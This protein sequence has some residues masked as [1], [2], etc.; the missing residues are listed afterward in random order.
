MI[1]LISKFSSD[2]RGAMSLI[3]CFMALFLTGAI[4][5]V[6]GVADSM[7]YRERVQDGADAVAFAGAVYHARGMNIIVTLNIL[8]AALLGLV[9]L[10]RLLRFL[11][12]TANVISCG[13]TAVPFIGAVCGSIC[14]VT[15]SARGPLRT[16][17][18]NLTNLYNRLGP[19]LSK[20]QR[21]VALAMPWI[22]E[23]KAVG[24]SLRYGPDVRFGAIASFSMVKLPR[25]ER[26]G[27]PVQEGDDSVL[28]GK[29]SSGIVDLVFKP[30][31]GIP[32]S[33]LV[34]GWLEGPLEGFVASFCG[35]GDLIDPEKAEEIKREEEEDQIDEICDWQRNI[36]RALAQPYLPGAMMSIQTA[37][38]DHAAGDVGKDLTRLQCYS[39]QRNQLLAGLPAFGAYQGQSIPDDVREVPDVGDLMD[40][41]TGDAPTQTSL[42][43]P[44]DRNRCENE[45][46]SDI[47]ARRAQAEQE[48]GGE[49]AEIDPEARRET[50]PKI[51]YAPAH[52]G[53]PYFQ[54]W[55]IVYANDARASKPAKG[56]EI[57]ADGR[58]R[59]DAVDFW[60]RLGWAQAEFYFDHEGAW[61]E[62][63]SENQA[64]WN[65]RWRA[66]LRRVTPPTV[67]ILEDAMGSLIGKIESRLS[68]V[69]GLDGNG[70][71]GDDEDSPS[72]ILDLL[73]RFG[74][75]GARQPIEERLN[76]LATDADNSI[77]GEGRRAWR[78]VGGVH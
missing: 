44:F 11:N 58:R 3:G 75:D 69:L 6:V 48:N 40:G 23:V 17:E 49:S 64:M 73:L 56:V 39:L 14:S 71:N 19:I 47:R 27:L 45:A 53:D 50:T 4:W 38:A 25:D 74:Y 12:D 63:I 5:Y 57:A 1:R 20:T 30:F 36:S 8:M 34:K 62:D 41:G 18:T 22:A 66:R 7:M 67:N 10:A 55:S 76:G 78:R 46:R 28:C 42:G 37:R 70:E 72:D 33:G 31:D 54:V 29:V 15:S 2:R 61:T 51:V 65:L 9:V 77:E 43:C 24:V 32:G 68:Q 52:N 59:A 35:G 13:C 60:A 16:L 21:G 26:L